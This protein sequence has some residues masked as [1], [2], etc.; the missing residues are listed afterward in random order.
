MNSPQGSQKLGKYNIL[1]KIGQGAMG[2][3][4]KAKD[5]VLQRQVAIKTMAGTPSFED[6]ELLQLFR[7]EAQAAAGLNHPNI[8]TVFDFGENDDKLYIVMELLEGSDLFHVIR[9]KRLKR[10]REKV[11]L[12]R[13]I[14]EGMAHAHSQ[15]FVHRDLKPANIRVLPDGT[16]KILDFGLARAREAE[17][18]RTGRIVGTPHYMS[19]E[20][21]RNERIDAR[22]DVFALGVLFYEMLTGE[23][24]FPATDLHGVLYQIIQREPAPARSLNPLVPRT[25]DLILERALAKSPADRYRDAGELRAAL[26]QLNLTELDALEVE[27]IEVEAGS[28][29]ILDPSSAAR[30]ADS[31]PSNGPPKS[32]PTSGGP[33]TSLLSGP[34]IRV[35]FQQEAG[36]D[37]E[38]LLKDRRKSLLD[39]ALENGITHYHECGGRARCSSCR[40]R[41]TSGLVNLEAR[42]STEERLARRLDWPDEVR[43]ACQ[44]RVTGEVGARRL[45]HDTQDL[46]LLVPIQAQALAPKERPLAVLTCELVDFKE[47]ME[48][49][50]A[51]DLFHILNRFFLQVGEAA[52]ATGGRIE[53]YS[54]AGFRAFFGL[55]GGSAREKCLDAVRAAVRATTRMEGFSA[56]TRNVFSTQFHLGVGLDFTRIVVGHVGHPS[57]TE[58]AALGTAAQRSARFGRAHERN[59]SSILASEGFVNVA[60]DELQ[61]GRTLADERIDN[62][63]VT[64]YEVLDLKKNDAAF[65]VQ[66]NFELCEGKLDEMADTFYELLFGLAPHVRALFSGTDMKIQRQMLMETLAVAIRGLDDL[67]SLIPVLRQL[68]ARHVGYGVQLQHYELVEHVLIETVQRMVGEEFTDDARLAWTKIYNVIVH[69]MTEGI[70]PTASAPSAGSKTASEMP[71]AAMPVSVLAPSG[72][73]ASGG[74]IAAAA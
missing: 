37:K 18:T 73:S 61:L 21:V 26:E 58:I 34:P 71:A 59:R 48:R 63:V 17:A 47:Q 15:G 12:M 25:I 3:V 28:E 42:T 67:D 33:P 54:E 24:P 74:G 4:Y 29:Q 2:E 16:P 49:L 36:G 14:A 1:E 55:D 9:D 32:G 50:P 68:G 11:E 10:L 60:E 43:L 22:A 53:S 72:V 45:V 70:L 35:V 51:Y 23:R 7:R 56:Y 13:R 31:L 69:H 44:T 40:V 30:P 52:I 20:Q 46:G 19:P 27:A 8:V 38:L 57:K 64:L 62:Q 39:L 65:V 41:V 5:E 66:K 6:H